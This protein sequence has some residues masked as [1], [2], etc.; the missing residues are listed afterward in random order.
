MKPNTVVNATV[1]SVETYG[2]RLAHA[3][4]V[5]LVLIPE[6][7]WDSSRVSDCRE[8]TSV[9]AKF[10]V[11]I[12]RYVPESKHYLGSL[13]QV[14]PE[15]DPWANPMRFGVGTLWNGTINRLMY[16]SGCDQIAGYMVELVNGVCGFLKYTEGEKT[17]K[18]GDTT[19]VTIAESDVNSQRILL[20]TASPEKC[21]TKR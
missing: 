18:I 5:I 16:K 17:R 2:I 6:V 19:D 9:G 11:K 21:R 7:T 10:D 3:D 15:A 1:T 12:L 8:F 13:R 14:H 20:R 4:D